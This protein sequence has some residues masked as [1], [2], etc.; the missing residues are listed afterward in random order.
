MRPT[1][2]ITIRAP[3]LGVGYVISEPIPPRK[4]QGYH[5]A[6]KK[7]TPA[8]TAHPPGSLCIHLGTGQLPAFA[9]A[10]APASRKGTTPSMGPRSTACLLVTREMIWDRPGG[11][12]WGSALPQPF[13]IR[14][15][16]P[17][18]LRSVHACLHSHRSRV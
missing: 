15:S 16:G 4:G 11:R 5:C 9:Q 10:L 17:Q 3:F 8:A 14:P 1:N 6:T 18:E 12:P 13:C 7:P 2:H